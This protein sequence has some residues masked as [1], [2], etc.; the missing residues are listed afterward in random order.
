M[1]SLLDFINLISYRQTIFKMLALEQSAQS[2]FLASGGGRA[3]GPTPLNSGLH[4]QNQ[5]LTHAA[6]DS[7]RMIVGSLGFHHRVAQD[8]DQLSHSRFHTG[9]PL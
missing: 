5:C 7:K 3:T 4:A 9:T 6:I 8:S 1:V 2:D